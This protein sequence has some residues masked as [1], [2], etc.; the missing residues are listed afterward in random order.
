[1]TETWQD[2]PLTSTPY[3]SGT[4]ARDPFTGRTK[5]DRESVLDLARRH[6][7]SVRED[8]TQDDLFISASITKEGKRV[9]LSLW[10]GTDRNIANARVQNIP[11]PQGQS[12][13]I[14]ERVEAFLVGVECSCDLDQVD[15]YFW[16]RRTN[17]GC[18]VHGEA[19]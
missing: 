13:P 4:T 14:R 17:P 3:A 10:K 16:E 6:G 9:D 5:S 2:A 8:S 19:Q 11:L 15:L 12:F 18:L 7:W 1:M